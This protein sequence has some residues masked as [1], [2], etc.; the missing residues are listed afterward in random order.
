MVLVYDAQHI[1][2]MKELKITKVES[3]SLS[4]LL[5]YILL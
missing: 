1:K 3:S 5:L 4:L 2:G